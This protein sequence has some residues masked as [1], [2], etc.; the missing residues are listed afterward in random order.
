MYDD[1]VWNKGNSY[2]KKEDIDINI[3]NKNKNFWNIYINN[4][5]IKIH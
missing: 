1:V 5:L 4:K 3:K 2:L